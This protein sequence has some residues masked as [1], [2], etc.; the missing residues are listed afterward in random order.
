MSKKRNNKESMICLMPKTSPPPK[1]RVSLWPPSSP[2]LKPLDNA[3]WGVLEN[4]NIA[5]SHANIGVLTAAI[6]EKFKRISEKFILKACKS[7]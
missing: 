3:T 7:F 1:I 6:K 5:T 4:K 2:D